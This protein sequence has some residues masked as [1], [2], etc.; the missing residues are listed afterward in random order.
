MMADFDIAIERVLLNE[1]I[2]ANDPQDRGGLTRFG[3]SKKAYPD[4]DVASLTLE[5]AKN[6]YRRD[7]WRFDGL[8]SQ[9]VANKVLDLCVNFGRFWGIKL[10]QS[11]CC[12]QGY[13][14]PVDGSCGPVTVDAANTCQ[15][16]VLLQDLR[17][18]AAQRYQ[19]IAQRDPSQLKFLNGWL[20]RAAQ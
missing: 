1:G 13:T 18:R 12:D 8:S 4:E 9:A 7:Y 15:P 19:E 11:S 6:L 3:I 2:D 5:D 10:L 20:A 16:D 17:R 14:V